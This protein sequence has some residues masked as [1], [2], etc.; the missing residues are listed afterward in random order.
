MALGVES[1]PNE[2]KPAKPVESNRRSLAKALSWRVVATLVTGLLVTLMSGEWELGAK[3]SVA[4]TTFKFLLYFAHE[5]VW[6]RV[7]FG[8]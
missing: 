8:R 2:P 1:L 6:S 4:D 3:V 5:R 7:G